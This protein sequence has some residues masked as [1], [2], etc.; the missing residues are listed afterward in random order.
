MLSA[1]DPVFGKKPEIDDQV[2]VDFGDSHNAHPEIF[3]GR[4]EDL[5]EDGVKVDGQWFTWT[6]MAHIEVTS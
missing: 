5:A 3:G 6:S 4:V 1:H 2:Y